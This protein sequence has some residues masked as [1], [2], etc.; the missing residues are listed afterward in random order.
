MPGSANAAVPGSTSVGS[1]GAASHDGP[2]PP[3]TL[4]AEVVRHAEQ[5]HEHLHRVLGDG[6]TD[7]VHRPGTGQV[8][9]G[10]LGDRLDDAAVVRAGG[11]AEEPVVDAPA[12]GVLR[13][14]E[15]DRRV[16]H[17][18]PPADGLTRESVDTVAAV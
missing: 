7:Q 14:V 10:P 6:R 11:G 18:T 1:I 3:E 15:G 16:T 9:E 17:R 8:T 13:P 4:R 2:D 12:A 5:R